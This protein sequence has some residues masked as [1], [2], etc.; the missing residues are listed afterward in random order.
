MNK[1]RHKVAALLVLLATFAHG[2]AQAAPKRVEAF[3]GNVWREI[4]VTLK[5][6][7]VILFSAT[8]CPNCPAV[9]ENLAREI[10][11]RKRPAQLLTV[12]MDV[13]PGEADAALI[14]NPHYRLADHLF[15]FAGQNAVI[16][17]AVDPKWQ[18]LTPFVV[19]LAPNAAPFS[20]IGQPTKA[21]YERWMRNAFN[22][23]SPAPTGDLVPR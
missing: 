10:K 11:Q 3:D 17:Y 20:V 1:S 23:V 14:A 4:Q 22:G 12:V 18:G 19:F 8:W 2:P 16:Q 9:M 21:N 13:A 15:A 5:Q 6:P 7:T